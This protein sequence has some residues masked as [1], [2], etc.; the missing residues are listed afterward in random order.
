MFTSELRRFAPAMLGGKLVKGNVK[1]REGV[2]Q[3]E[4]LACCLNSSLATDAALKAA[5]LRLNL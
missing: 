5:A 4:T 3:R 1:Q 2:E